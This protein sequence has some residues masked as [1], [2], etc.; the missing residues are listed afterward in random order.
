MLVMNWL[1]NMEII[2]D[3][4]GKS[5]VITREDKIKCKD[6]DWRSVR[7]MQCDVRTLSLLAGFEDGGRSCEPRTVAVSNVEKTRKCILP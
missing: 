2:L 6:R 5:N 3:Y 1:D 7:I 4:S